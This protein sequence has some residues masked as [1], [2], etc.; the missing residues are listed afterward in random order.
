MPFGQYNLSRIQ[1]L[2][3][4]IQG[5]ATSLVERAKAQG[6]SL[7]IVQA[8]RSPDQQQALYTSGAGVTNAPALSSYHNYGLAFDVV[9]QDYISL[10]DWNPS[11]PLW[12]QIG[13]LGESLGLEWGGRW[14]KPDRPH[15]QIPESAA[16]LSELKAYWLKFQKIMP[17]EITPA[18]GGLLAIL[19]I[20]G[21]WVF[22]LK[23]MLEERGIL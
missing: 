7:E 15:F 12:A 16:P 5:L 14:H 11:G 2:Q 9:P 22:F 17:V 4:S 8:Y 3:P 23:P 1:T 19:V 6:I 20:A 18:A 13:A 10:K 21:A